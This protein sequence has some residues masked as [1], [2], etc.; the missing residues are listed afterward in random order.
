LAAQEEQFS[1][2]SV[3]FE[4][5]LQCQAATHDG[6]QFAVL[7][8][9]ALLS[10]E[11]VLLT[12]RTRVPKH[13]EGSAQSPLTG[14]PSTICGGSRE[15]LRSLI[16]VELRGHVEVTDAAE[17]VQE[18][19]K[20]HG[21][22]TSERP[23]VEPETRDGVIGTRTATSGVELAVAQN[24]VELGTRYS[25]SDDNGDSGMA[26]VNGTGGAAGMNGVGA[27]MKPDGGISTQSAALADM[28]IAEMQNYLNFVAGSNPNG[29]VSPQKVVCLQAAILRLCRSWES[30][31]CTLS[32][33]RCPA[34]RPGC[35]DVPG[36]SPSKGRAE[37][38]GAVIQ[39]CHA[40]DV[41][42]GGQAE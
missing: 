35:G 13:R 36:T 39:L 6:L 23:G 25:L 31:P 32:D 19:R 1:R 21:L 17:M 38:R 22:F 24:T 28:G 15:A 20:A 9:L 7:R 37:L 40:T 30:H 4:E 2:V 18:L 16:N 33:P 12:Q 34:Y 29:V 26:G 42:R 27:G 10:R 3:F 11:V 8:C 41:L 14:I 5:E